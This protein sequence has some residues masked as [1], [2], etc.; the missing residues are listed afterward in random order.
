MNDDLANRENIENI[1][2]SKGDEHMDHD[3]TWKDLIK[4][5]LPYL[6]K[7]AI[8]ELYR[9]ADTRAEPKFENTGCN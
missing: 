4:K 9:E 5:F 6:L 1:A 7:R 2:D 8:P 3:G